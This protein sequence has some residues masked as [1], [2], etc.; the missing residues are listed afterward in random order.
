MAPDTLAVRGV[1]THRVGL[2][3][4]LWAWR[5]ARELMSIRGTGVPRG[6]QSTQSRSDFGGT[7]LWVAAETNC[8][9]TS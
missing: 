8:D 4:A 3:S 6:H 7:S 9:W 1:L 5:L 2:L